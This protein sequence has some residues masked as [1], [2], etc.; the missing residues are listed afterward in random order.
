MVTR[1]SRAYRLFEFEKKIKKLKID[2]FY[3]KRENRKVSLLVSDTASL[4]KQYAV[5]VYQICLDHPEIDSIYNR[6]LDEAR[7]FIEGRETA[8]N[9][10]RMEDTKLEISKY[11]GLVEGEV[12]NFT[13]KL[14]DECNSLLNLPQDGDSC[15]FFGYVRKKKYYTLIRDHTANKE[16]TWDIE[17]AF[18]ILMKINEILNE[19]G[20]ALIK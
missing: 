12:L 16:L 4:L 13:I 7:N 3:N 14:E 11:I 6:I 5:E 19:C 15:Y 10:R 17:V 8:F 2:M 18:F 9:Y 1:D 20:I